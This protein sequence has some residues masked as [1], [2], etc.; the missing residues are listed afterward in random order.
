MAIQVHHLAVLP[1]CRRHL[2]RQ[3]AHRDLTR[4][5]EHLESHESEWIETPMASRNKG[6][7]K[8]WREQIKK[9]ENGKACSEVGLLDEEL[10]RGC[11]KFFGFMARWIMK[12]VDSSKKGLSVPLPEKISMEVASLPDYLVSDVAEFL[13]F[14]NMYA[15]AVLEDPVM[16]DIVTFLVVF[17][18]SPNYISN[19]YLVA[20]IVEVLFVMNPHIQPVASK[21]HEMILS[22]PLAMGN[23]APALMNFY[24]GTFS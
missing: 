16:S 21:I 17:V 18:C 9:L 4:M 14:V 8:K 6:L 13:L 10:L 12:L 1:A 15:Y 3:R 24:T 7:L 5:I 20:K 19:P 23:L 11:L 22:H 2:R